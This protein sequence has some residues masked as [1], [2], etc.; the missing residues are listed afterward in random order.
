M[1]F[2]SVWP[3]WWI[4]CRQHNIIF[5]GHDP[6]WSRDNHDQCALD[7]VDFVNRPW[8]IVLINEPGYDPR[9][10]DLQRVLMCSECRG[11]GAMT[12]MVSHIVNGIV[13]GTAGRVIVTCEGCGGKGYR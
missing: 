13:I 9:D 4:R 10:R 12:A 2:A 11:H 1:A 8:F 7:N 3:E 6:I 5:A